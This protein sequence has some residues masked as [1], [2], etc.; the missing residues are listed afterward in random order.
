MTAA[1]IIRSAAALAI[2][3]A[4]TVALYLAL[5]NVPEAN[6]TSL[7]LSA[8]LVL[9]IV[10]AAGLTAGLAA[11]LPAHGW[12]A[13]LRRAAAGMPAFIIGLLLVAALFVVLDRLESWWGL[14]RGEVDAMLL[15]YIGTRS[16]APLHTAVAWLLWLVRWG[17]GLSLVL[18][19]VVAAA[20]GS[21]RRGIRLALAAVPLVA[22]M[23]AAVVLSQGVWRIVYWRP[24][25]LPATSLEVAFVAAKLIVLYLAAALVAGIVIG[26]YRR[27]ARVLIDAHPVR[28]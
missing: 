14:H 21:P 26:V 9:L 28:A 12:R 2:G 25:G 23:L 19:P 20:G 18:G 5:L 24:E 8:V 16:T 17:V 13:A 10:L 7:L 3:A 27:A 15:P 11:A 1:G 22:M 4:A 6:V